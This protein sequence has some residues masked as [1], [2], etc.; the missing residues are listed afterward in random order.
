M[1]SKHLA[2]A[3]VAMAGLVASMAANAVAPAIDPQGIPA[4]QRF[5]ISGSTALGNAFKNYMSLDVTL[6]GGGVCNHG[7]IN[8]FSDGA[9]LK[10]ATEFMVTCVSHAAIGTLAAGSNI[11]IIDDNTG[12]SL[13]GTLP[14]IHAAN[15]RP[16][17]FDVDTGGAGAFVATCAAPVQ[18]NALAPLEVGAGHTFPHGDI[19]SA[20]YGSCGRKTAAK[21]PTNGFADVNA[22]LF[23]VGAEPISAADIAQLAGTP[24]YQQEFGVAV[25]LN[26]YRTLQRAQGK[27]VTDA[28]VDMPSL[29]MQT[30]RS[31]FAQ[32]PAG[33]GALTTDWTLVLDDAGAAV[34]THDA[35]ANQ[36]APVAIAPNGATQIYVCRRG[37]SSG[38]QA[39]QD[40]YL[41]GNRC[42]GGILG[43][44]TST[45]TPVA[46]CA[47]CTAAQCTAMNAGAPCNAGFITGTPN[48]LGP[49]TVGGTYQQIPN[50]TGCK[51]NSANNKADVIFAGNGTGDVDSCLNDHDLNNAFAIGIMSGDRAYDD[52]IAGNPNV[53]GGFGGSGDATPKVA[54]ANLNNEKLHAWR[55]IAID[56]K[57]P[58]LESVA[59]GIYDDVWNNVAYTGPLGHAQNAHDADFKALLVSGGVNAMTQTTV[60]VDIQV[61]QAH[62]TTGGILEPQAT[63]VAALSPANI[64][65][66][67]VS[68]LSKAWSGNNDCQPT[69]QF[70]S[71]GDGIAIFNRPSDAPAPAAVPAPL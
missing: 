3:G 45:T 17:Y 32:S 69:V 49:C 13:E 46:S 29:S 10:A 30:L 11:M 65:T 59:N 6:S 35:G 63:A 60:L 9:S 68:A 16:D 42:I 37:D 58:N 7:T 62:G 48:A 18:W 71:A 33:S 64:A 67:P 44:V 43:F 4:A 2:A 66:N 39:S 36:T 12:G 1:I 28:A 41:L 21:T 8:I 27:G 70:N 34:T 47:A 24:L 23:T 50:E 38:T 26:L 56:Q 52:L 55:F 51:Y 31:I 15:A 40:A 57:K 53:N 61:S 20:F 25:S 14:L 54:N 19:N 22:E 5:Y